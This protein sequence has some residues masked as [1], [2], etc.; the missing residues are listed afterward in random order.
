MV[1]ILTEGG[2]LL[3]D[4]DYTLILDNS[5]V[6]IPNSDNHNLWSIIEN[7]TLAIANKCEEYD[8]DGLSLYLYGEKFSKFEHIK[9]HQIAHIFDTNQPSGKANLAIVLEEALNNYFQRR[10]LGYG[11]SNGET[12]IVILGSF[13]ESPQ[14]VEKVIINAANQISQDEQLAIL[15][16]QIGF[17]QQLTELLTKWDHDLIKLGAKFDICDFILLEEVK[18]DILA[19]LL[20]KAIID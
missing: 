15:F 20:L 5:Q 10:T 11:K 6:M 7:A 4:R 3:G 17:N 2:S 13:P 19:E 16:I 9:A 18:P 8:F 14:E 12:F 1:D